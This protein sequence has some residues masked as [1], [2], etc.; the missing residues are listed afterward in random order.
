ML[1][2]SEIPSYDAN[3]RKPFIFLRGTVEHP[4]ARRMLPRACTALL[5]A[6]CAGS[7][8]AFLIPPSAVSAAPGV[9]WLELRPGLRLELSE[10]QTELEVASGLQVG[11]AGAAKVAAALRRVPLLTTLVLGSNNITASG[12]SMLAGALYN[13]PALTSLTIESNA[14]IGDEGAAALAAALRHLPLLTTFRL[15]GCGVGDVGAAEIAGALHRIPGLQTLDVSSNAIRNDGLT[16]LASVLHRMPDLALLDVSNNDDDM[17]LWQ[18]PIEKAAKGRPIEVKS[19]SRLDALVNRT[20]A[21][22]MFMGFLA[23]AV[24]HCVATWLSLLCSKVH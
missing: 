20:I 2:L 9:F 14:R 15:S 18:H 10:A 22:S 7:A 17:S 3:I 1:L 13:V 6:A 23:M 4:Y 8:S 12:A 21:V 16:S 11:D 19:W 24:F 5:L